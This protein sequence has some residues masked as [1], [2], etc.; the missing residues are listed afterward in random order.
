MTQVFEPEVASVLDEQIREAAIHDLQTGKMSAPEWYKHPELEGITGAGDGDSGVMGVSATDREKVTIYNTMTGQPS[1]TLIYMVSKKLTQPRPDGKPWWTLN[2]AAAPEW[3]TGTMLCLLH[4]D[5][6]DREL[7][8][9]IGLR[10]RTCQPTT[11]KHK[12]NIDSDFA[13]EDHM[14]A[15]HKREWAIIEAHREREERDAERD[16]QRQLM[17]RLAGAQP[18]GKAS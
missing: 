1:Q 18:R 6:P 15:K 5:H 7:W 9:R 8:D 14:R 2:K 12:A 4:P 16:W 10:G 13:L 11:G 3:V 17:E